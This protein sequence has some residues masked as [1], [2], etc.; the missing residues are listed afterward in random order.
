MQVIGVN[1]NK[2]ARYTLSSL[3]WALLEIDSLSM[4]ERAYL[5]K[6]KYLMPIQLSYNQLYSIRSIAKVREKAITLEVPNLRD[7]PTPKAIEVS[8]VMTIS[9]LGRSFKITF[10]SVPS[11][12]FKEI[13]EDVKN[14]Q[15]RWFDSTGKFWTVPITEATIRDVFE[16]A[17]KYDFRIEESAISAIV[18]FVS[19]GADNSPYAERIDTDLPLM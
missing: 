8:R 11:H 19:A 12:L 16:L 13:L 10:N 15:G 1:A 14:L 6:V 2:D 18:D 5:D 3:A 9:G 17:A 4:G 7:L